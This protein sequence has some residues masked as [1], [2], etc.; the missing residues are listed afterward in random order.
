MHIFKILLESEVETVPS[1]EDKPAESED[2]NQGLLY[3]G[4]FFLIAFNIFIGPTSESS[5]DST[6]T[7]QTTEA[8][9]S[10]TEDTNQGWLFIGLFSFNVLKI[11]LEPALESAQELAAEAQPTEV[12]PNETEDT[13]QGKN[14]FFYK[15]R[16]FL[17]LKNL[18]F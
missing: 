10:E 16:F 9:P 5:H 11:F 2:K 3:I 4:L 15:I 8:K 18:T 17:I 7:T 1:T 12:K 14:L 6:A 13:V